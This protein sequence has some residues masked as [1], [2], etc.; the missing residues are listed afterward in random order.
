M[1]N[2]FYNEKLQDKFDALENKVEDFAQSAK[3]TISDI[4]ML[5]SKIRKLGL[6]VKVSTFSHSDRE[7]SGS[8]TENTQFYENFYY[9]EWDCIEGTW[10]LF[11]KVEEGYGDVMVDPNCISSVYSHSVR[12][13]NQNQE[14]QMK[15]G[16]VL[17]AFL[18]NIASVLEEQKNTEC[19]WQDF[20]HDETDTEI[21]A[22]ESFAKRLGD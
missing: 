11:S 15:A 3:E 14:I 5:E 21:V 12:L 20:V 18:D 4:K 19:D 1:T 8:G 2:M 22:L 16:K 7:F 17:T 9:V 6:E 13:V 10:G